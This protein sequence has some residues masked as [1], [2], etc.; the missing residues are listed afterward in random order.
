MKILELNYDRALCNKTGGFSLLGRVPI[1]TF[2]PDSSLIKGGKPFFVPD[3][4]GRISGQVWVCARVGRLGKNI[5]SRF[6]HR[7]VD[8]LTIA[9]AFTAV[10][11]AETLLARGLSPDIAYSLDGSTSVGDF[12]PL[13]DACWCGGKLHYDVRSGC[14]VVQGALDNAVDGLDRSVEDISRIFSLR[15][16][17]LLLTKRIGESFNVEPNLHIDGYAGSR[18]LLSFNVK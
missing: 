12:L 7:Y 15:E 13:S 1:V 8:A 2:R 5:P 6:A 3:F 4:L 10:D 14:E 17:D 16:G 18:L 11:S 9:V